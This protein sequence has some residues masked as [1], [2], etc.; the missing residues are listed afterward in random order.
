M[1]FFEESEVVIPVQVREELV[2]ELEEELGE[3]IRVVEADPVTDSCLGRGERAAIAV[4][5]EEDLLLMND[6]KATE[7]ASKE[8]LRTVTI[9]GF[10]EVVKRE[11]GEEVTSDLAN[12]LREEDN[13]RFSKQEIDGLNLDSHR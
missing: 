9:P 10:L 3:K 11:R 5:D 13:Y 1:K 6:R 2:Q 12:Q 4:A 7:R 8:G